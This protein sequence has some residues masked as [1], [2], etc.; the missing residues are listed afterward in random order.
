MATEFPF[1]TARWKSHSQSIR[2]EGSARRIAS[3][4]RQLD[5]TYERRMMLEVE[6]WKGWPPVRNF[7]VAVRSCRKI[8][9]VGLTTNAGRWV[10]MKKGD[11]KMA[12][13]SRVRGF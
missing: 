6:K 11:V 8:Q 13:K 3:L 7:Q 12:L 5:R 9:Q 4:Y 2:Y 10:E 1:V